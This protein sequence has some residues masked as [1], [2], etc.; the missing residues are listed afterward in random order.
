MKGNNFVRLL[1]FKVFKLFKGS[2]KLSLLSKKIILY[3]SFEND[4]SLTN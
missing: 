2:I 3:L 4:N 1:T